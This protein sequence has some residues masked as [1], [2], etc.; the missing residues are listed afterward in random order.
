MAQRGG[1]PHYGQAIAVAMR[2]GILKK[3]Q[4][5]ESLLAGG[6]FLSSS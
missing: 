5:G 3:E 1:T 4:G 6:D 2:A